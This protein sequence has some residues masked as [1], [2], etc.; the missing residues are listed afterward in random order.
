M[1]LLSTYILFNKLFITRH[2]PRSPRN[3]RKNSAIAFVEN[4]ADW[5]WLSWSLTIEIYSVLIFIQVP[6]SYSVYH[7]DRTQWSH[8]TEDQPR[9]PGGRWW[10]GGPPPGQSHTSRSCS[11]LN[12]YSAR[13]GLVLETK[14][15][16][17]VVSVSVQAVRPKHQSV[18]LMQLTG[19]FNRCVISYTP[20]QSINTNAFWGLL[21]QKSPL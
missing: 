3:L 17:L 7:G 2:Q 8:R 6:E 15:K 16:T 5:I 19:S 4:K 11:W 9:R 18:R 21:W 13:L 12:G 10:W 14:T 20:I 1:T